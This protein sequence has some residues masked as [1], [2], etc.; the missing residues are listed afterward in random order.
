MN[1]I[2]RKIW[3]KALGRIVVA[4]EL[5]SS[6]GGG[7]TVGAVGTQR[8]GAHARLAL[9][10]ALAL[11]SMGAHAQ[12]MD[13]GPD[14]SVTAG[15]TVLDNE[16]LRVGAA[17]AIG[18]NAI[19]VG[20]LVMDAGN[21]ELRGLS[22]R[23]W[24]ANGSY[25]AGRAAT[26]EQLK[27][28]SDSA[29]AGWN[30]AVGGSSANIGPGGTVTFQGDSN[31]T[32]TQTGTDDNGAVRVA[33]N[34]NLN[35]GAAGSVT[36]GAT[37][38]NNTGLRITNGPSVATTGINAGNRVVTGVA[39]GAITATS[40][41]AVNGGQIYSLRDELYTVGAGVKYFHANSAA[42]DSQA[43]GGQSVAIGP[44]TIAEGYH[45]IAA[46]DGANT[47]LTAE[48]AIAMGRGANTDAARSVVLG[49]QATI[50]TRY[51]DDAIVIGTRAHVDGVQVAPA[52]AAIA[53]GMDAST[54]ADSSIV[55]GSAASVDSE[56][57][58]DSI[59]IGSN[60][61]AE[62]MTAIEAVAI[63]V[64]ARVTATQATAVGTDAQALGANSIALGQA[65]ASGG[66]AIAAG[67]AAE[68]ET[69]D[70]IS[71]GSGAGVGTVG[72]AAGDRTSHIAIGTGAGTNVAG[73]QT[74]AIG[75]QAGANVT[76]DQNIAIGSQAGSGLTGDFNV[77]IGYQAN[78]GVGNR[79]RSVAVG[80]GA[81][82]DS[83]ATAFGYGATA[84]GVGAV[85]VGTESNAGAHGVALGRNT[86]AENGNVALG[87]ASEA[88]NSDLVGNGYLTG[89]A[90][91][92]NVVSVGN[93]SAGAQRR[94]VNVADGAQR[95]DAVNVG[96]L[97][98]TQQT[99]A[100]LIGGEV[101]VDPASG[102]FS[103]ITLRDTNNNEFKFNT[104]T[105][106]LGAVTN[107][108]VSTLPANAVVRNAGGGISNINAGVL[109]TDAV[110]LTQLNETV[111]NN[112]SKYVSIKST[113][114]ANR[115][116]A[117]ATG[118]NATA[119]GPQ[120][121]ATGNEALAL[122]Y[123]TRAQA[124]SAVAIG[125]D[126][127]ALGVASTV[128]GNES[129]A[130]GRSGI[131]IGDR[132]VSSGNNSIT[133]GTDAQ[134]DPKSPVATVNNAIVIGTEAEVSA[135][136]GIAMGRSALASEERAVAQGYDA[137]ATGI[138]A[139]AEGTRARAS[140]LRSQA[141]GTD[142]QA[143][144]VDAIASGTDSR[145][146]A[147]NGVA[148]GR[149][150]VAGIANPLPADVANN[151]N[152]VAI[153]NGAQAVQNSATALGNG[154]SA[155]A[156]SA[157][158]VGTNASSTGVSAHA[159]G[160]NARATAESAIA[161]GTGASATAQYAV[162]V[163]ATSQATAVN[164][165][166]AGFNAQAS[167]AD[168]F[169]L[170]RG[171]RASGPDAI[172][173]GRDAI[174]AEADAVAL[175]H[176]SV[177]AAAVGTANATV[178]NVNYAF[179]GTTPGS[180]VSVG[181]D[182]I[183]R[184][185][186]NVAA[187]RISGTSTDAINGSQL[188]AT[189]RAVTAL[190]TNLDSV[191]G[192]IAS[193]LGGNSFYNSGA[194]QVVTSFQLGSNTYTTVGSALT[195]AASGINLTAQGANATNVGPTSTIG[196][197]MDL[198]SANNNLAVTK[199]TDSNT[200]E[201]KLAE[202]ID[203][204][205]DGSLK[206][207]N[208]RV[209][210]AGVAITDGTLSNITNAGSSVVRD[211]SAATTVT[212]GNVA[213]GAGGNT[214][215]IGATSVAVGG[216]NPLLVDGTSGTVTGLTNKT[217][218]PT[219]ITSGRAASE[220]QLLQVSNVANAGWNVTDAGGNAANIGPNGQVTFTGDANLDV[221]Q[222]GAD[223]AG[224]VGIALKK[225][226]DL[227]T[228][229]SVTTGGTV[230]DTNGV[231]INNGMGS[232][233]VGGGIALL[234]DGTRFTAVTAG[235]VAVFD[236]AHTSQLN[237]TNLQVG[238]ANPVVVDGMAG[239]VKGLSNKT[240][241]PANIVSGQ[242]ASEDQLLQVSNLANAGWNVTDANGN[243]AN[244]GPNGQVTF[245][246]D[247][248]L[249]VAQTGADDA[250]VVGIALKKQIDLGSTGSVTTGNTL[251][252][253]NGVVVNNGTAFAST[254]VDGLTVGNA[255][256]ATTVGA[257]SVVVGGASPIVV[258]GAGGTVT[259]LTNKTFD[260]GNFTS[261]RAASEDQLAAVSQTV[262][263]GWDIS[264]DGQNGSKVSSTS[265]T[266]S[267]VDLRSADGNV[268]LTKTTGSNDVA[269]GLADDIDLGANGSVTAGNTTLDTH[270]L[271]VTDGTSTTGIGATAITVGGA[272]TLVLNGATGTIGG[273]SN[274]TFDP[275]NVTSGQAA[276][277]DQLKQVSDVANAGWNVADANGNSANIGPNGKVTFTGDS[278]LDVA[279][280]G[281]DDAGV[282]AITLK[283][284]L[285]LGS[286]GS[287]TTGN[288][289]LD[290]AGV[291]VNDGTSSSVLG[292][293]S[294]A[295]SDGT[296]GSN[297]GATAI[298]VGGA[299]T[300]L[301]NGA[302][303]T[304]GGL[305]NKTFDPANITSGQAA[306]EDQLKQVSDVANAGW[307]VTDA[308][309][310]TAN[311]G[312]NGK[313]TFTGDSNLDVAQ[314]GADDAGVVAITLKQNLDL[315][316]T[317]SVVIGNTLLNNNGLTLVGGP[318]ITSAGIDAGGSR[319]TNVAAGVDGT[320][321]VNLD[322]MG[323]AIE[324][325]RTRYYSVN[326]T[327]GGNE[328]NDGATGADAIAAGRDAEADGDQAV[329]MGVG[330]VAAGTGSL[331]LGAGANAQAVNSLAFGSGAVASHGNSIAMGAGSATTVGAQANYQ[332]A[333][334]GNSSS[335]GEM[336]LGGRQVTGVAAGS[337]A[338]DAVNVSQ[339]NAGVASAVGDS[340][341]Y[342]DTQIG[343]VN[344][345][346]DGIDNRVTTIE[347][348][349]IDIRG[350]ITDIRNDVVDIQG[351]ITDLDG[352]MTSVEGDIRNANQV[353]GTTAAKVT[354]IEYGADG[355]F[356]VSQTGDLVK[357]L[358]TGQNA[359][360]GGNG[361][362]ASGTNSTA[363]GNQAVASGAN[364]TAIGQGAVAS[365]DNSVALGQGSKTTV[366]AQTGYNA[367]Y[368]GSSTSTGE[369]NIGGR[370]LTGVAAGIAGTDATNVN[371]LTA[372]VNQAITSAN[373]YTDA[374]IGK[375][376]D[377][378]WQLDRGYRSATAAAMAMAGLPQA[379]LPGKSMLSMA[380]GGYQSE[381]GMALG[382]SG[383]TDNGRWVYKAQASGN[384]MRD[385]GFSV[386]AGLQW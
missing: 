332:G 258:N 129:Y 9:G 23:T 279:Q 356:Q 386:G 310:N 331:A 102:N 32:L 18:A 67:N 334:V 190:G 350:D 127:N 189:N 201:F 111:A 316:S 381:Y 311:I 206:T 53:I 158:A 303:G 33:L 145:G 257:T 271:S 249:D 92:S 7:G 101:S 5:A 36:T 345:R 1:K 241:D 35:L 262:S 253:N 295:V 37:T 79:E 377:D 205:V 43:V 248:N 149:G 151:I 55:I 114:A 15:Q 379:Y 209:D 360:A 240:F 75:F 254:T 289:V 97:R 154:A 80:S 90:P 204:G 112:S 292:A 220:D 343:T 361:A 161:S 178:D 170:G 116:N 349:L 235:N 302:T 354:D 221:A 50:G 76:G 10:V 47:D 214:T 177:T 54:K 49:D 301:L 144:G 196:S 34:P 358:P 139:M 247:D 268:V 100:N 217:F 215:L 113:D 91:T 85:A 290:N 317:G 20:S 237:T 305:S 121:D 159:T 171:S 255:V 69:P 207:G 322:Q 275:A 233:M 130:Y 212:A 293:G 300:L 81:S 232:T 239:T 56:Y 369:V 73:N 200:V 74:T 335:T 223:D 323:D 347:G 365:H 277:E 383:I 238:G 172:A 41:E 304:I 229:G 132:A 187:G 28:V 367:A 181:T 150:A 6:D 234:S 120:A 339:L 298:T 162:A 13:L 17:V 107:G 128:V 272:N 376:E 93:T 2:Y 333:Y 315:G 384:T 83:D 95:Y 191:G 320:D 362:V 213:V 286:T 197:T 236:G 280:T 26:E 352:R 66:S 96:Q 374:R 222:T 314:T 307:N 357:P 231:Q 52:N 244:I 282:V 202:D 135:D 291:A 363:L 45:S 167:G 51:A 337:A 246:G 165:F 340:K 110:N 24:N 242:A 143:S 153:G 250:G 160:T 321:A 42:A 368:V 19:S 366:G 137:H 29:N 371:Q 72:N 141:S 21:N 267:T 294:L 218:N 288:T 136:D 306:S 166:A 270:G 118:S 147:V 31:I 11:A 344:T 30:V 39:N 259:G 8:G 16:G 278:N 152:A 193:G 86:V 346:I 274:K 287:I 283:Q 188:F 185:V 71:L 140:G 182:T 260:A 68:A 62:G 313:V 124:A 342:T 104:V 227:G 325:G 251:V 84:Q 142:A 364:S 380:F 78:N 265:A 164:S 64:N 385:W 103:Q 123:R 14:G 297:V 308:G 70:S 82:A 133:I 341:Q 183:K 155:S 105:E 173:F 60:A 296:Y 230:V 353:A 109:G 180:T 46:G 284:N 224:V 63:G 94:I 336:N 157:Y 3:N 309:G 61:R 195:R 216:A 329:A 98:A 219:S 88:R 372:G 12:D 198:R 256:G 44:N 330:A 312:P 211:G 261:G 318:S 4:S 186:T 131:A 351:D 108:T 378:L 58:T 65:T 359:V 375:V 77:A 328:A 263:A 327:G 194:H 59:A 355:M 57:A 382:L 138:D 174:A 117:G 169:A 156:A 269:F 115:D 119:I 245:T 264:A 243:T 228:A 373:Q 126:V 40:T 184:T 324:A 273:L 199:T 285:D 27:V 225:Q 203:L 252:N 89:T 99:V 168:A 148:L 210:N 175:G 192:S 338:T 266:G 226:I 370:T 179:A 38:V 122:G 106:A 87:F 134:A 281:A 48:A 299:N 163:G 276:S 25:T 22:N 326:S 146:Y 125:S 176:N 208:T 319:I 348:D